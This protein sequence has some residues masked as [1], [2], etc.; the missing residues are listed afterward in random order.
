MCLHSCLWLVGVGILSIP[1]ALAQGGWL[2]LILLF[3][4]AVLC[5]YTG[6][7]LQRC[8]DTHPLVNSYPDIGTLAFGSKGRNIVSFFMYLE[9]YLVAVEF[10]ILEGDNLDKLFPNTELNLSSV[11]I[12]GKQLFVLLT[13]LVVLPSTW[14]RSL[15]VL[16]YVSVGGVVASLVLVVCVFWVGEVD[17]VGFDEKGELVNWFGTPT[18]LSLFTFCYCGHA[19]F[20]TLSNSMK[21]RSQ[22]SK[23]YLSLNISLLVRICMLNEIMYCEQ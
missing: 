8:M 6:L 4:L 16:A 17:G 13:A 5:W 12:H 18:T 1:Y 20:P 10:L 23:V 21:D 19:V 9:L 7:L 3:V 15:G 11:R 2:T 14:L 22:F